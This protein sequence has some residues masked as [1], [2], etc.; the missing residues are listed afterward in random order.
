MGDPSG[1]PSNPLFAAAGA[2]AAAAGAGM[3]AA[4][5][6]GGNPLFDSQH[7][8]H[9]GYYEFAVP[10]EDAAGMAEG[11]P[12][13]NPLFNVSSAAG[14]VGAGGSQ[15]AG[16][17][18]NPLYDSHHSALSVPDSPAGQQ[19]GGGAAE[20]AGGSMA[21]PAANPLYG[22][23]GPAAEPTWPGANPIYDSHHSALSVPDSPAGQQYGEVAA[24]QEAAGSSAAA[25]DAASNP[26]F[27]G[28]GAAAPQ[29]Q[30]SWEGNGGFVVLFAGRS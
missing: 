26:L 10:V 2:A 8:A 23:M 20:A 28:G 13:S 15:A 4:A 17:G 22:R 16:P 27:G 25:A 29:G 9:S 21:D 5:G 11:G 1:A 24:G 6:A 3:G 14:V 18:A 19:Y 30:V 7:S 12:S